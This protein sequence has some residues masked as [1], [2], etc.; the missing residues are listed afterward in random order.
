MNAQE[1]LSQ[2]QQARQQRPLFLEK[3]K[4][5]Q[6]EGLKVAK[7]SAD[8]LKKQFS[9]T[10]V[11]LFGSLLNPETMSPHSDID[12][13]VWGLPETDLFRAGAMIERGHQF[14]IDL[15]E[16]EKAKPHILKAIYQ[17]IEIRQFP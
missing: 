14:T 9:V 5:R 12:L 6:K 3:M 11:V 2:I 1:I 10:R 16:A 13:A 17:G 15:V 7:Q 8:I 4:Q